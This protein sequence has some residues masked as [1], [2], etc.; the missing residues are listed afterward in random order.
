MNTDNSP[1]LKKVDLVRAQL[2]DSAAVIAGLCDKAEQIDEAATALASVLCAGNKILTAGNGGSAA[3]AMHLSEELVGKF[4]SVRKAL[5]AVCLCS[6]CTALT[7]IANDFSYEE[8]FSRQVEALGR[9]GDLLV[10]ISTSGNSPNVVR[11]VDAARAKGLSVLCLLGRDGG[12]LAGRG[13]FEII[14]SAGETERIQESHQVLIH[15]FLDRIERVLSED[16]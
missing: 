2:E 10:A 7:C 9:K 5:P 8:V 3:E 4:R 13:D 11:A 16:E 15:I 6:D 12:S 1:G 14:T